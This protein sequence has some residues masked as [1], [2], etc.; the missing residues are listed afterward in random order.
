MG[1]LDTSN[2]KGHS[3][4][5]SIVENSDPS[6]SSKSIQFWFDAPLFC[7]TMGFYN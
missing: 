4:M 3:F 5:T 1:I 7:T 2:N 6:P